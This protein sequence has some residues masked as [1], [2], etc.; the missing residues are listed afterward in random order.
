M[1]TFVAC[2]SEV[3]KVEAYDSTAVWKVFEFPKVMEMGRSRKQYTERC[4]RGTQGT[5]CTKI[6]GGNQ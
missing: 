6:S 2:V 1:I 3:I 5:E 4:Q